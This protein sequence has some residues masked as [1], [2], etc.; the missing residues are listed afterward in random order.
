MLYNYLVVQGRGELSGYEFRDSCTAKMD[1][2]FFHFSFF[3]FCF[4][5]SF[6]IFHFPFSIFGPI[7]RE[8]GE[9]KSEK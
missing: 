8:G 7:F 3:V 1:V 5:F 2:F 6:F 9:G 4:H